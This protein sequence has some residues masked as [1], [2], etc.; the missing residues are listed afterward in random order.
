LFKRLFVENRCQNSGK[1]EDAFLPVDHR[2]FRIRGF[3]LKPF[4]PCFNPPGNS[5]SELAV[6][7]Q[8]KSQENKEAWLALH[9]IGIY[10][11]SPH[12]NCGGLYGQCPTV[13]ASRYC[14]C[15]SIRLF[16]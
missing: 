1:E 16:K 13:R 15:R 2:S 5:I 12:G 11:G 7:D 8:G 10:E 14:A 3:V 4:L 6:D 9:Y